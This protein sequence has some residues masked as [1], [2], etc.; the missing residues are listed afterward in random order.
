M[1]LKYGT[2]SFDANATMVAA[3][4][5]TT[6]NK[7]GQPFSQVRGL[8]VQGW[9]TGD[10]QA[11]LTLAEN[12]LRTALAVPFKDLVLYHDDG[13]QSSL[14]LL[15]AGSLTGVRVVQGPDF[16][17]TQ[18][19]EFATIRTFSFACEAE[20]P[21][22]G[23]ATLLL[24]FHETLSFSGG[25]PIY[26]MRRAI[27]GPPQRQL[28]YPQSEYRCT[29]QGRAT[30]YRAY[31]VPQGP[32]FPAALKEA[33]SFTRQSPRRMGPHSWQEYPVEWRYE[34]E[35]VGPLVGVPAVWT[36]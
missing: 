31:P 30:G 36:K 3:S 10:G 4:I 16:A 12:A 23:T 27:N 7:G 14:L 32:M 5:R 28:V 2:Y 22:S 18:G 17:T 25:G 26:A 1:Q 6:W 15:N 11:A 33:G 24:D 13:S 21:L 29:Q 35:S 9:L 19:P 20:Y 34:F 8:S